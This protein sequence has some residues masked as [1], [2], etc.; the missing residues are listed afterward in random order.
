MRYVVSIPNKSVFLLQNKKEQSC[1]A[2]QNAVT[3]HITK[4]AFVDH[5]VRPSA[6][7]NS[8]DSCFVL[9]IAFCIL[10]PH[11]NYV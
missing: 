1:V 11:M 9:N 7:K 4:R 2:K 3:F 10:L 6:L 5:D 8:A